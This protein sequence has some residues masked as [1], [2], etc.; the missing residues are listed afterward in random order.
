MHK[1]IASVLIHPSTK[2][3]TKDKRLRETAE[4]LHIHNR[5][6]LNWSESS[7][8]RCCTEQLFRG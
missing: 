3:W 4:D 2:I 6:R 5:S 7:G 8:Y 1:L